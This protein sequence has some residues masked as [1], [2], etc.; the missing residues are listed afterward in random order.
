MLQNNTKAIGYVQRLSGAEILAAI[1][2]ADL[3][4]AG[5]A[6]VPVPEKLVPAAH[7]VGALNNA[8]CD[9]V[10]AAVAAQN[11]AGIAAGLAAIC[12]AVSASRGLLILQQGN[13]AVAEALQSAGDAT[14]LDLALGISDTVDVRTHT[15]DVVV[16]LV[17]L[18]AVADLLT[19]ATPAAVVSVDGTLREAAFGSRLR[20]IVPSE[21]ARAVRINHTFYPAG[22]LDEPLQREFALGS[23]VIA[24]LKESDCIAEETRKELLRLREKCCGKCTFCREGLF[25]LSA[26]FTEITEARSK[27]SELDLAKE[28]GET[29]KISVMCSLGRISSAP[30][31][32]ACEHFGEELDQ[33]L[34]KKVCPSGACKAYCTLYI[35]PSKCR[36]NGQC[37]EVCPADCIEGKDGFISMIDE[38]AC[39]KCGKCVDACPEGAVRYA[40]GRLPALPGR[41]TRVGRFRGR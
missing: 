23:G 1:R 8:D 19:G 9:G 41:L 4:E 6:A 21:G 15:D 27:P 18:A 33:H 26:I 12:K 17:T 31:L 28:I 3:R 30:V 40:S 2:R 38:F 25:Q 10:L 29:M 16:H 11:P 39:I 32:S 34:R 7:V 22:I 5:S 24:C 20:D 36:G 35:D 37:I 13:G 14:G